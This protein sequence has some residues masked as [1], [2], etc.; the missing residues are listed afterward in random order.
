MNKLKS[1]IKN[2]IALPNKKLLELIQK[3]IKVNIVSKFIIKIFSKEYNYYTEC[4]WRN[5]VK[6]RTI[7]ERTEEYNW[8][9]R[10]N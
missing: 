4:F 7:Y 5:I 9:F 10:K 8:I 3:E 2:N 6:A 1:V